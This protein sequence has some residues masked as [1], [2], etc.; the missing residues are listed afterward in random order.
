MRKSLLALLAIAL[1][2]PVAASAQ[3]YPE[4]KEPGP[5]A[6]KPKGPFKTYT[7]CAKKGKC[8]FRTIQAAVN[9]ADAGDTIRV[10]DGVYREAV[11]VNGSKKRYL[12]L[13]GNPS[14]PSKVLLRARG[15]MQNGF[16]VNDADEVT[17]DGFMAG[18]YKSNGFFFTNLHG[19]TMNHLIARQTGGLRAVRVQHHRRVDPEFRGVLRQ[20]QRLLHRPDAAAGQAG[21]HDGSERLGLGLA[22][23]LQRDEHAVRNDH[24]VAVL[25]Q[26]AR[27]GPERAGQREVPAR[28]R[29]RDHRQR[30]L[31][32]QLQLPPGQAAV[33]GPF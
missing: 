32:E 6:P 8:D 30:H 22:A 15:S 19:Y 2:A 27:Q 17:V 26:R 3:T 29:Q 13:I 14:N 7:V 20:R 31:L 24:Q 18:G 12:K 1:I 25:Q 9:A 5:V 28:R 10:R 33:P 21:A 23:R 11:K 4:P 16:F